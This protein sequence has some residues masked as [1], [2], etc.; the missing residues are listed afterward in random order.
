MTQPVRTQS[1]PDCF[2]CGATGERLY[3]DLTDR[4]FNAPVRLANQTVYAAGMRF[5]VA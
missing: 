2:L 1:R 4:L 3:T 5:V